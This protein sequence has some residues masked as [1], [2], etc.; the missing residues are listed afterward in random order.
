MN[1]Y[2]NYILHESKSNIY[3]KIKNINDSIYYR[4]GFD[5][6]IQKFFLV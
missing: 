3:I 5:K 4:N 1:Y 2:H 6:P